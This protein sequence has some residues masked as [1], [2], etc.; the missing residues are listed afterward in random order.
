MSVV[1]EFPVKW[2]QVIYHYVFTSTLYRKL[3]AYRTCVFYIYDYYVWG[4]LEKKVLS[5]VIGW[6]LKTRS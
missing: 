3:F 2:K 4:I 1:T 6:K 5:H